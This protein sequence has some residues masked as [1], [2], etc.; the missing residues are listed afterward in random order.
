MPLRQAGNP[1]T[2]TLVV[3]RREEIEDSD[4]IVISEQNERS[5]LSIGVTL[6]CYVTPE[7]SSLHT[8]KFYP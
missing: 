5:N 4:S 8:N 6:H 2:P 7:Y 3:M 1:S